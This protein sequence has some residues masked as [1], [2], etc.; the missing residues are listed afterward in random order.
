MVLLFLMQQ[1]DMWLRNPG[2]PLPEQ[3]RA[4]AAA[5]ATS[6]VPLTLPAIDP[7]QGPQPLEEKPAHP[8][9]NPRK[10]WAARRRWPTDG[11]MAWRG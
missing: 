10:P 7:L 6:P 4:V 2:P 8:L 9:A 3:V 1:I 5:L 11:E